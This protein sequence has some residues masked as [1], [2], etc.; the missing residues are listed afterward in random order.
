MGGDPEGPVSTWHHH[1][2][3]VMNS[4]TTRSS[5]LPQIGDHISIALLAGVYSLVAAASLKYYATY[6]HLTSLIWPVSGLAVGALL[7]Y[8]RQLWPGVLI[9]AFLGSYSTGM[10]ALPSILIA[11]GNTLE[12]LCV[13]WL[14]THVCN[15]DSK[16]P[17]LRDYN[18]FLLAGPGLASFLG[19]G[20]N[21]I[22]LLL[23]ELAPS[24]EFFDIWTLWWMGKAL[25]MV[26]VAPLI[27]CI[28]VRED[29]PKMAPWPASLLFWSFGFSF[30]A[31]C[32]MVFGQWWPPA[33]GATPRGYVIFPFMVWAAMGLGRHVT[34][35]VGA[36]VAG[37]A[38]LSDSLNVGLFSRTV[39]DKGL[40]EVWLFCFAANIS[41]MM[42]ATLLAERR[43]TEAALRL[44][45]SRLASSESNFRSLAES[46]TVLIWVS[47]PD[48]LCTWFNNAWL[49]FT[50]RSMNQE[51]GNGWAEGVHP[52]DIE[53]C[54][55]IYDEAFDAR[56]PFSMDYRLRH[57]SGT[58]RW[59]SDQGAPRIDDEGLFLG[60]TGACWDITE[61][62][63]AE[64]ALKER[65]RLMRTIYDASS[66]AIFLVDTQGRIT[67]ANQRMAEI[68]GW[69]LNDLTG[70]EYVEHIHPD[71]RDIGRS[72]M[73]ALMASEIDHVDLER[74]Y[75]KRDGSQF[76]GHLTGRRLISEDGRL[77][78]LVGV[79]ADESLR[80]SAQDQLKLAARVFEVSMEGIVITDSSNRIVSINRAFTE[81]TGYTQNETLGK[82]PSLLSSGRHSPAFYAA[83]WAQ[84]GERGTWSGEIWNRKKNGDIFPEWLSIAALR[85]DHGNTENYIAI[86]SDITVR[87]E[88]EAHIRRLAQFDHLTDLPNRVLLYDRLNQIHANALRHQRRFAVLFL[89]LD[90]FKPINDIHGHAIGDEVLK[91]VAQ[92]LR[93]SIRASDTVARN[94]GDE[95][96]ITVPEVNSPDEVARLGGKLLE[97]IDAPYLVNNLVL[98]VTPSIGVSLYP[99]DGEDIDTLMRVA[100]QAMYQAKAA[101][102]NAMFFASPAH[103]GLNR[104]LN[105]EFDPA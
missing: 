19:A 60:Y 43:A 78:G 100:D 65:E 96:V 59:V 8:G 42:I 54:L 57:A 49:T 46:A 36:L 80:K 104:V 84:L 29:L 50:G 72:R 85:D 16:L 20:I 52:D 99:D 26:V 70:T 25:G 28:N 56:R 32:A 93:D 94:G 37:L 44:S 31:M 39:S 68:F 10:A 92:R 64:F 51:I 11:L 17:R 75:W 61:Q 40:S 3:H 5:W 55:R 90:H 30:S 12:A 101:G 23:L 35:L 62:R 83:M 74:H 71:E 66:V 13:P 79:I 7:R 91:L 105:S 67:H 69:P 98:S 45:E 18:A 77:V 6:S 76:W 27:L 89:D 2:A 82:T 24:D 41:G 1:R 21:T 81:I 33:F 4:A 86:F 47:G 87:K 53:K 63:Q 97:V 34:A 73:L 95:F 88:A 58:Y 14:L 103:A 9:G 48:R 15:Y 22:V 102:R 38:I